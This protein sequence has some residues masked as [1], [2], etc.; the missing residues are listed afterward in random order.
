VRLLFALRLALAVGVAAISVG[1]LFACQCSGSYFDLNTGWEA[2]KIETNGSTAIFEGTPEHFEVMWSVFSAK[3]GAW[4]PMESY[5]RPD[6][7]GSPKMIVTFR[8]QRA[9]KGDLGPELKIETGLGGG[10]C[11]AV[12]APGVTYLVF[13]RNSPSGV[14][15]V[16]MCSP[17]GWIGDEHRAVEL[18][19]LRKEHPVASDLAPPRRWG[20][21]QYVAQQEERKRDYEVFEKRYSAVTGEICGKVVA[22]NAKDRNAGMISFLFAEGF[23]P[24][25]APMMNVG[26]DGSFCS[27]RL[28]PGKYFLY[29]N[30]H[31]DDDPTYAAYYPG[32]P[33]REKAVTIEVHAGENLPGI[34]FKVPAQ[35]TYSVRGVLSIYDSA[36]TGHHRTS[37][38]LV[39][40]DAVAFPIVRRLNI[41]F[42]GSSALPK[43]KYFHFENVPPGR[44]T[45]YISML[46]QGWHT[47]KEEINVTNHMKFVSL[48]L[49]HQK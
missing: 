31:A 43:I 35:K 12:Y 42:E 38:E 44:Y 37:L 40:L 25:A 9:Y 16:S 11:G 7:T 5:S 1:P 46:G 6:L 17:G 32:V 8:V 41:D 24:Y 19:Y 33:G 13:V 4:I 36:R 10:D 2:A 27:G 22:E 18:R 15:G 29:F 47:R 21:K 39:N 30:G 28:G 49:V 34:T 20:P 23:S 26:A 3:V 45:A 48:E 14:P